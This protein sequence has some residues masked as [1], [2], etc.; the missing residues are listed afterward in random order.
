MRFIILPCVTW[1]ICFNHAIVALPIDLYWSLVNFSGRFCINQ[2]LNEVTMV[3]HMRVV[4][5]PYSRVLRSCD[6]RHLT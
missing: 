2:K 1:L 5:E 4:L 3:F 6:I